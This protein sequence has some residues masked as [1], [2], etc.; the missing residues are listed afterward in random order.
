MAKSKTKKGK[1]KARTKLSKDIQDLLVPVDVFNLGNEDDCFGN[2]HDPKAEECN[3]CG[4]CELCQIYTGQKLKAIRG[5]IEDSGKF[6]DI[7][8]KGIMGDTTKRDAKKDVRKIIRAHGTI[9][10]DILVSEIVNKHPKLMDE[11]SARKLIEGMSKKTDK[12]T[13]KKSKLIW[14]K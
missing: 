4:D 13:I 12:F 11:K 5:K 2:L 14:S 6:R 3:R 1:R 7:D 9:E 8:E 10:M